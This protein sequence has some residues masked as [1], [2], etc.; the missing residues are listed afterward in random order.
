MSTLGEEFKEK[1]AAF[2]DA[3][4]AAPTP[5]ARST[6]NSIHS[7]KESV[8][9]EQARSGEDG[10]PLEPV[11]SSMYPS[12]AKLIPILVAIVM[13]VFLVALDMTIIATAIPA[14]TD[15]FH[16][17]QDVGWYGSAFFLTIAGFQSTWGKILLPKRR[18]K[19]FANHTHHC[20]QGLQVF[21]FEN[22]LPHCGLLLR[23]WKSHL[24]S[25]S[26]HKSADRRACHSRCRWCWYRVRLL[27]HPGLFC[28][29]S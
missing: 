21:P 22:Q 3:S 29:T 4:T 27:H 7:S 16:S 6:T 19:T 5:M 9:K 20:R 25:C 13:S 11:E 18:V 12:M 8:E 26:Q 14:I 24:R 15:Q 28:P 17:L 2:D 1:E 23:T 10:G